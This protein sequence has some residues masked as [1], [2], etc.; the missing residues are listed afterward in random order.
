MNLYFV[1]L[2]M[3]LQWSEWNDIG[4]AIRSVWGLFGVSLGWFWVCWGLKSVLGSIW[5]LFGVCL[6]SA[7][8]LLGVWS[9]WG[10]I[11]TAPTTTT[12]TTTLRLAFPRSSSYHQHARGR[13]GVV[14][15]WWRLRGYGGYG[16]MEVMGL[17]CYGAA[18]QLVS[19]EPWCSFV[20]P[21]WF[22]G[23][24]S[25]PSN[26]PIGVSIM[27]FFFFFFFSFVLNIFGFSLFSLFWC[28]T[29][30]FY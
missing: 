22:P 5:G 20:L 1:P 9:T 24:A 10:Q 6:G 30:C 11:V 26:Q 29:F 15:A 13:S 18:L 27:F 12:T 17:W 8:G 28:V 19:H 3:K 4:A 25:S 14:G 21:W 16:V 23:E 7:W 2:M